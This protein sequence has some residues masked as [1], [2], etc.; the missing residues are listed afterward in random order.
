MHDLFSLQDLQKYLDDSTSGCIY[1]SFGTTVNSAY[2]SKDQKGI[3]VNV[4]KE[5]APMR[6]LWKFDE[7][8]VADGAD[9][10]EVRTWVPQQDILRKYLM[11]HFLV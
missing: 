11:W 8:T 1:V 4:F 3:L 9:N 7:V 6:V 2:L 5:M 10:V